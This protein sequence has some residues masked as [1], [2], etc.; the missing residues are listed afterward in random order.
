M[1]TKDGFIQGYN[2]Q[3]AWST[4]R[5]GDRRAR[6]R[7]EARAININGADG[8]RHR[9]Q[10]GKKPTQLSADAAIAP[11]ANLMAMEERIDAYIVPGGRSTPGRRGGAAALPPCAKFKPTGIQPCTA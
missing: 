4:H 10:S 2:A 9:S 8:R 6:P 1:K 11:D 7:R 5:A 3:A